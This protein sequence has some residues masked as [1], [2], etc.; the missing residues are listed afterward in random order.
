ME[1]SEY[2]AETFH[3]AGLK[4][5]TLW[6]DFALKAVYFLKGAASV[7]SDMV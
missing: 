1:Y 4:G 7:S 2:E 6:G 3:A 5:L